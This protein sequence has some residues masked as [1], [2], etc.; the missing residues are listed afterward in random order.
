MKSLKSIIGFC[1][2]CIAFY[3]GAGFSTMQELMQYDAA[4]GS[5]FWISVLV[6]AAIY[7]Y[8]NLSF[9]SNGN[10]VGLKRG[11]DIY[12]V[13][14]GKY[15]GKFFD[16]FSAFFC[17]MCFVVMCGG[18][19]ATAME[20]WNLPN[21]VGAII[22]TILV[23]VTVVFGLNGMLKALKVMGP[24]L[25]LLILFIAGYTSIRDFGNFQEGLSIVDS[26]K[27]DI[28]HVGKSPWEAGASYGGFVILW[29]AAFL[30]EIG[31]KNKVREVNLGMI[32]SAIAIF[33]VAAVCSIALIA[34]I[35]TTWDLGI[36]AL[37]L[38]KSI[39]PIFAAVFA[40]IIY[41]CIFTTACPLL[42]TGIRELAEDGSKRYKILT[43]VGGV[44]GCLIACLFPYKG[45]LHVLYGM[46]GYLGFI[47]VAFMIVNDVKVWG[48]KKTEK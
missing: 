5:T 10:R 15:I 44:I 42:W 43:L 30:G 28:E 22:L 38:A 48:A 19:N 17:Y 1:T 20:Q 7:I 37:A 3:I 40:V 21:G 14:C 9:T 39:H 16:V 35:D 33:G 18:A 12:K 4:F 32:I 29:F 27:Y 31:A 45:L 41:L 6:A 36:P 23:I 26:G 47:L 34:N 13:Y 2:A 8:T 46:N 11:G 24:V 25:I